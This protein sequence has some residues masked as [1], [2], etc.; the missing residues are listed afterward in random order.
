MLKQHSGNSMRK[1]NVKIT[2]SA[3]SDMEEIYLYISEELQSPTNAIR[4]Y[5]RI[6]DGIRNLDTFPERIRIMEL[7]DE[8]LKKISTV[9]CR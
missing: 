8:R 9:T 3:L 6:A 5:N 4:Q 2:D 7:E 1:Y